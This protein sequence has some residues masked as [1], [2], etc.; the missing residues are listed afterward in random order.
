MKLPLVFAIVCCA[1]LHAAEPP[2]C[3]WVFHG[4]GSSQ[5]KTRGVTFD[6][7]GNVFLASE[8]VGDAVFGD[9]TYR[10]AGGMDMCLVKLDPAGQVLWVNGLGGGKTDRA[11]GVATD[12]AGNAYV[13]GHFESPDAI[14]NGQPIPNAG[15]YDIYTAKYAPDGKLLWVRAAGGEGS[16]YGHG[17][18]VDPKGDI[19]VT[20]AIQGSGKFGDQ[21][22]E[23]EKGRAGIF[24]VKYEAEGKLIWLRHS[25]GLGGSGHGVAIDAG[26][27]IYIGGNA[28]GTG[29]F[30]EVAI[31]GKTGSA[32]ALKLSPAGDA[33]WASAI[34]GTP[35]ALYHE[36]TCD[37]AGRV[38]GVGMFRGSVTVAGKT[39]QSSG[40][41]DN[42]GLIV[43]LDAAGQ[44]QWAHHLHGP[45]TDYCLGVTTDDRGTAYVCGDFTADTALSGHPLK[46]RGSGDVF[47][48]AFDLQGTMTWVEQGGGARNDSAYPIAFRAPDRLVFA[49][50][51]SAPAM[52]GKRDVEKSNVGEFYGAMWKLKPAAR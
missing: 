13:T 12:A 22:L 30:G 15:N 46:T 52:F 7:E 37:S 10:N 17:I 24:C 34:P 6:R 36:I 9:K 20:G 18:A 35:G 43:Y 23:G 31:E 25:T 40:D 39:F 14:A 5:N 47:L 50:E 26:G 51:F 11:Y 32:L 2:E 16:D 38:W 49:G 28:S 41:K 42:D 33:I 21:A 19:V 1:T 44:P 4:G 27:N 3:E 48:A 8:C 45:G 29:K